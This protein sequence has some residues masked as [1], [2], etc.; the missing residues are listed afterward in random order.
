VALSTAPGPAHHP[1]GRCSPSLLFL[2]SVHLHFPSG[3][4]HSMLNFLNPWPGL[5]Q[6]GR[7][8]GVT[9]SLSSFACVFSPL[10]SLFRCF[11]LTFPDRFAENFYL[12]FWIPPRTFFFPFFFFPADF[13]G[14]ILL[15]GLPTISVF[16]VSNCFRTSRAPG[17]GLF[18]LS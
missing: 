11:V 9:F 7:A 4:T 1:T 12:P 14:C 3:A 5:W 13:L 6:G 10:T 2:F 15:F 18:G 8:R 17:F 16:P